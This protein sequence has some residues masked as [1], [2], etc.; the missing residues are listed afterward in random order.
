[1]TGR[2]RPIGALT[3][4][5][6]TLL[7][8]GCGPNNDAVDVQPLIDK[9]LQASGA[10]HVGYAALDTTGQLQ[11]TVWDGS[12]A[13]LWNV[14][15]DA[16]P[17]RSE[18]KPDAVPSGMAAV[19]GFDWA[20]L[21]AKAQA[22]QSDEC[23]AGGVH[24]QS[25]PNGQQ[26]EQLFCNYTT[27]VAGS[28]IIDGVAFPDSLDTSTAAGADEAFR[29]LEPLMPE[30]A[31][32]VDWFTPGQ[33]A[34]LSLTAATTYQNA[35]GED[36]ALVGTLN[37]SA[38]PNMPSAPPIVAVCV[39]GAV[40]VLADTEPATVAFMPSS[41][42]GAGLLAAYEQALAQAKFPA[43]HYGRGEVWGLP[44]GT[45]NFQMLSAEGLDYDIVNV[46]MPS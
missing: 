13:S 12:S 3:L 34:S 23:W 15:T 4:L 37:N 40:P 36:C 26:Q 46:A 25:L 39:A 28:T 24:W 8:A 27:Y 2:R 5:A 32:R 16:E 43:D 19:A 35:G 21:Y 33:Q 17:T 38:V 22:V 9:V 14:S 10:T 6:L 41:F 30:G 31:Y 45:L 29:L 18:E 11:L 1:M 44:D 20:G 7:A 42:G